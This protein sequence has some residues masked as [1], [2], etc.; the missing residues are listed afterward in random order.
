MSTENADASHS[1]IMIIGRHTIPNMLQCVACITFHILKIH[2]MQETTPSHWPVEL[3]YYCPPKVG[4][5]FCCQ[6][7]S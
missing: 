5:H 3:K 7:M 2:C 6:G 1:F 4:I